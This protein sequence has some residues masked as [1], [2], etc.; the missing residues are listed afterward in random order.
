MKRYSQTLGFLPGDALRSY[1]ERGGVLGATTD[2]GQL[3]GYL[4]YTPHTNYFRIFQLCVLEQYQGQGIAKQLVNTLKN[5][6]TTQKVIRLYCRRDYQAHDMWPKL[7]F[8][9]LGEKPGRSRERHPLTLWCFTLAPDDQLGLFQAKTSDETLDIIIDAQIFF[10]F[11]EP[12]SDKSMPSK[13]LLFDFLID[14][15]NLCITDELFNEINRQNDPEQR[16]KSCNR[17]HNF[18][19][20]KSAPH[21]VEVF[22]K[23]FREFLPSLKPS[24]ESDIRQLA[25]AA[26]SNVRTF[27]TR[28]RGLLKESEK[29]ADLTGL[30]VVDPVNLII[31]LHELSERQ[32]YAPDRIAGLNLYWR[33]LT[34]SDLASFPFDSFLEHQETKGG[35][36]VKLGALIAQ[37][38]RYKC[39]ILQT[40]NEI[41]A[42]RVLTNGFNKMLT[43][44]LARVAHSANRSLFGRFLIADTVSKAVEKN[45][46]R[47]KFEASALTSNLIPDLLEMGFIKCNDA[48]VR[49]CFSR[50]L[51]RKEVLSAISELYPESTSN[52]RNMSDLDLERVCS[53]LGLEA[54]DQKCFLIPIRPHYAT[55]LF[56]RSQS[57][58]DLFGGKPSVLLRWDNVYY[59]SKTHHK[60]LKPPARILWYVSGARQEIIA[61][62][63]LDAVEIDTPKVLFNKFKKFGILEW[64]EVYKLCDG[65]SSREIMALRF[66]HTFLFRE[67]VSLDKLRD[68]FKEDEVGLP[69]QSPSNVPMKTFRKLFRLGYPDQP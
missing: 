29:I 51:G 4:L 58:N 64:K 14:S 54:T 7:G 59:R 46:D 16:I 61:V 68:I 8:V 10:D 53:P 48:F 52:Y 1:L 25:N 22:D 37:P 57:A 45:L 41:I 21:L 27:V 69:L 30:E 3:V 33:R 17:A 11:N 63:H 28:D 56:D 31:R 40:G 62:S 35:F 19:R 20:S 12:D 18:F 44:S 24:Q 26:A 55:S 9:P 32:S 43:T 60:M 49:F 15:L 42:I 66:S 65:D 5:S 39:E 2:N 13:A 34:S 23:L 6:A 47:V 36:R 67:P 50:C 38:D